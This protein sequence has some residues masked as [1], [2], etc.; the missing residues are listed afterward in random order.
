VPQPDR[1]DALVAQWAPERPDLD[2]RTMATVARLLE[3]AR[4]VGASIAELAARRG[5]SV[6]EG[7]ILFTLRRSGPPYRLSPSRLSEHLL[8][9]SGTMTSRLDRLE[10]AGLVERVAHPSDRR[11][12]EVAL[13]DAGRRA[14]DEA[15][16]EHVTNEQ[17]LLSALSER[18]QA[19]LDRL[20][21]KLQAS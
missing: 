15:V 21:R 11:S 1:V 6:E 20:L 14:A 3:V 13:T 7:D 17:R 19:T 5:V 4:Q 12:V 18:D 9:P 16:T 8:V 10:K 2:L